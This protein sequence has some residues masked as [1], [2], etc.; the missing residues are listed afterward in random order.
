[1]KA[2]FEDPKGPLFLVLQL[3]SLPHHQKY[4]NPKSHPPFVKR[5]SKMSL[6]SSTSYLVF[7][8]DVI[9]HS[10]CYVLQKTPLKLGMTFQSYDLLKGCQNNRKQK[11]LFPLFGYLQI[12]ICNFRLILLDHIT[13]SG[14]NVCL[15][16][17]SDQRIMGWLTF[18]PEGDSRSSHHA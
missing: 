5:S 9:L 14:T 11:D 15:P 3:I 17:A 10:K 2:N 16:L 7:L 18:V 12:N 4:Y 6:N 8:L 13:F 1:M